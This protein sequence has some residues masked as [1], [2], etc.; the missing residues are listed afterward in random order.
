MTPLLLREVVEKRA[1]AAREEFADWLAVGQCMPGVIAV[2]IS[3]VVGYKRRGV[4]GGLVSALGMVF[5]SLVIITGIAAFLRNFSD[6]PAVKHAFAG[7]RVGV[8]V[9]IAGTVAKLWKASVPDK[10]AMV[11]FLLVLLFSVFVSLPLVIVIALAGGAGLVISEVR[12]RA[13]K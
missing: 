1:W 3:V 5:P 12:R 9:L 7:I 8:C 11:I 6:I 2:N 4:A 10:P 13:A